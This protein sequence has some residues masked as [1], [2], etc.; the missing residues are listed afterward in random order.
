MPH[1]VRADLVFLRP[2]LHRPGL[3]LRSRPDPATLETPD[4]PGSVVL[5]VETSLAEE[6]TRY[7]WIALLGLCMSLLPSVIARITRYYVD[8]V[9]VRFLVDPYWRGRYVP[10][11]SIYEAISF[12]FL[13]MLLISAA[14]Y[15]LESIEAGRRTGVDYRRMRDAS[16][17]QR[18][19][20]VS[21]LGT[22]R[23]PRT[24]MLLLKG[25]GFEAYRPMLDGRS[26]D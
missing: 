22:G 17:T 1:R 15:I 18:E 5:R 16:P 19:E 25:R 6:A 20:L 24:R 8:Y 3:V 23:W 12:F 7:R 21:V 2:D 26:H 4:D 9:P 13:V 11:V 10:F 14:S